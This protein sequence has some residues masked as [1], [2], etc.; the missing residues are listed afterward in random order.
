MASAKFNSLPALRKQNLLVEFAGLKQSCPEGI[1]VSLTPGDPALW[2][3]VVFVRDGAP[4]PG[5]F[6]LRHGF[7]DWF[8]RRSSSSRSRADSSREQQ[9]QTTTPPRN[10]PKSSS[11]GT[12]PGSRASAATT[13]NSPGFADTAKTDISTFEV[14]RYIRSTFDDEAVLDA[15]PLEA[16]GNPGAW[17]AWRTHRHDSGKGFLGNDINNEPAA[18]AACSAAARRRRRG[19]AAGP[20]QGRR[21]CSRRRRRRHP[22]ARGV[23]LGG[24]GE[25]RVKKGVDA[26]VSE[27]VLYGGTGAVAGDDVVSLLRR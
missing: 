8:G 24:R 20:R 7:P 3:G 2:T 9:A 23:E 6:S 1:F 19:P 4:A 14:L 12:T 17:H 21:A 25:A 13:G 18:A 26:S 16:A 27:A 5:G 15:I 22:K 10:P 11:G